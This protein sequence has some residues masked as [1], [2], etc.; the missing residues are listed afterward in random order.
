MSDE[1]KKSTGRKILEGLG[2]VTGGLL[3]AGAIAN[4]VRRE[5]ELEELEREQELDREEARQWAIEEMA[6]NIISRR[7]ASA[8]E[9]YALKR[10]QQI[11][12]KLNDQ[13]LRYRVRS[14]LRE[15]KKR[16]ERKL[17]LG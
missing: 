16:L 15:E 6:G 11:N 14:E 1:S 10:L 17:G 8:G 2:V 3:V 12:E 9:A 5:A 7:R 4:E 13:D